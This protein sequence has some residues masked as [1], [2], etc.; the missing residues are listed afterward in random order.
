MLGPTAVKGLGGGRTT[1]QCN[2]NAL[3]MKKSHKQVGGNEER[4]DAVCSSGCSG[5]TGKN[6]NLY[7]SKLA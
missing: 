4:M 3:G 6:V 7:A 1:Q 5:L 2:G